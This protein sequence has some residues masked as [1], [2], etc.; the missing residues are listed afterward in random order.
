M[1]GKKEK[2][3]QQN[4]GVINVIGEGSVIDGNLTSTGDLR[5]DG[6]VN[7]NVRTESK[8]VLGPSGKIVGNIEARSCDISGKV[9]GNV[10]VADLLLIKSTG[11]VNGDITTAKIV[12]EN[13]G[14]FNGSCTMGSSVSMSSSDKGANGKAVSA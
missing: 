6:E 10:R 1:I 7:G 4:I 9:D 13:G 3:T 12:V 11:K 14:E 8:C 5:I 2:A